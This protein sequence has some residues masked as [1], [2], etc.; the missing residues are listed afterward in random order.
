M[1]ERERAE[2]LAALE[3]VAHVLIFAELTPT[4]ALAQLRPDVHCKGAEYAPPHGRPIPERAAVEAYGGRVAF[5]PLSEGLSTSE[6]IERI[7]RLR[8]GR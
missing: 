2:V 7:G 4:A 6:L 1:P 8:E 3:C 5:L